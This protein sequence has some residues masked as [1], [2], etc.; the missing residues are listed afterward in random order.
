MILLSV[1]N[2]IIQAEDIG[3]DEIKTVIKRLMWRKIAGMDQIRCEYLIC[4]GSVGS[5]GYKDGLIWFSDNFH[6]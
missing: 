1:E 3:L 6:T 5:V 4:S 2:K